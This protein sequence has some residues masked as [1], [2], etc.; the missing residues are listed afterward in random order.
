MTDPARRLPP[1]ERLA[2]A[3]PPVTLPGARPQTLTDEDVLEQARLLDVTWRDGGGFWGW[4]K[5]T[6]ICY[7]RTPQGG[8]GIGH[9]REGG[10]LRLPW[11]PLA[12]WS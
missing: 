4:E 10:T 6:L 3:A 2:A 8:V 1:H 7:Y 5:K 11:N 9:G 12:K